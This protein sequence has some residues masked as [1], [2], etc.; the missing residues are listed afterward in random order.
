MCP[1]NGKG[2]RLHVYSLALG[3]HQS[4]DHLVLPFA[5]LCSLMEELLADVVGSKTI[6]L[7]FVISMNDQNSAIM[8]RGDK[9]L[10][11]FEFVRK[12]KAGNDFTGDLIRVSYRRLYSPV[13]QTRRSSSEHP[14]FEHIFDLADM[15]FSDTTCG[16]ICVCPFPYQ[17]REIQIGNAP[18]SWFYSTI[19][20]QTQDIFRMSHA[21]LPNPLD[22]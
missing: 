10:L 17:R 19:V 7:E 9:R 12:L 11:V 1:K 20:I 16:W 21:I 18:M 3:C 13:E 22:T 4:F 15:N 8:N 14:N 6:I 2:L 5:L